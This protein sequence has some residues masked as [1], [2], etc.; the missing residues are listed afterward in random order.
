MVNHKFEIYKIKREIKRNG[1]S[2]I[3]WRFPINEFGEID[4]DKG[5]VY[6]CTIKGMYHEF[7]AHMAD[8]YIVLQDSENVTKRTKKTPQSLCEYDNVLFKNENGEDD[9]IK[10]GDYV[11]YNYR[12]MRVSGL[13][14]IMEWN[15]L[16]DISFEGV[17]DGTDAY[18]RRKQ[19]S[20]KDEFGV[21]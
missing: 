20:N 8:T 3:Y 13:Q 4:R 18:I 7:T 1:I 5:P 16:V 14:N 9:S 12:V 2:F 17:D 19:E 10:V 21:Y 15:A 6:L 11:Y